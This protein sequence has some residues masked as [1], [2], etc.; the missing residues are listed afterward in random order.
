M[1]DMLRDL[2]DEA[3]IEEVAEDAGPTCTARERSPENWSAS[4][5]LLLV[6]DR[7]RMMQ[8]RGSSRKRLR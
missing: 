2:E 8:R 7:C 3:E 6:R 4:S 5:L 1:V